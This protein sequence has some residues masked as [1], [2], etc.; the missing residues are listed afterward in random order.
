VRHAI[1]IGDHEIESEK[2]KLRDLEKGSEKEL[3]IEQIAEIL[4]VNKTSV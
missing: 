3:T 1:F 4:K 2:Y